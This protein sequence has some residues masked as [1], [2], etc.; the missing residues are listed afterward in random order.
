MK[1]DLTKTNGSSP[2]ASLLTHP[3]IYTRADE[4][5]WTVGELAECLKMSPGQ[6]GELSGRRTQEQNECL[7]PCFKAH[8]KALPFKASPVQHSL[9][10]SVWQGLIVVIREVSSGRDA[11]PRKTEQEQ[12]EAQQEHMS[13]PIV[14]ENGGGL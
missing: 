2:P 11:L 5:I 14:S 3:P 7:L 10:T 4:R 13:V 1:I 6:V 9:E 12:V 8:S